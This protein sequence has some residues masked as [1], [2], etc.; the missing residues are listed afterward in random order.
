ML[1]LLLTLCVI[2][3]STYRSY[4][5][6]LGAAQQQM[7]TLARALEEHVGRTT[8]A[9]IESLQLIRENPQIKAC[10][11]NQDQACLHQELQRIATRFSQVGSFTLI[12]P[13]GDLLASSAVDHVPP[14]NLSQTHYFRIVNAQPGL[15]WYVAEQQP[16]PLGGANVIPIVAN[17]E[18]SHGVTGA[19]LVATLRPDYFYRFYKTE[20]TERLT[21]RLFRNDGI[22]LLRYPP[23]ETEIGRDISFMRFFDEVFS[24]GTAGVSTE[25]SPVDHQTLIFGWRRVDNRPLGIAVGVN[26]NDVLLAWQR[27]QVVNGVIVLLMIAAGALLLIYVL[28]QLTR[29]EKA[30]FDLYLTRAAVERGA[31]MAVWLDRNGRICYVNTIGCQRLGYTEQALRNMRLSDINPA[32]RGDAWPRFWERLSRHKHLVEESSL[33]TRTGQVFPIE[34]YSNYIVFKGEEYNCAVVRDISERRMAEQAIVRSEQ[35]LRLALEASATGLFDMP[36]D[37]RTAAVT[38][39]EYDRLLGYEPGEMVETFEKWKNQLHPDDR[40]DVLDALRSYYN[41]AAAQFAIEYRRRTR[42]GQY[43]WFQCRGRLVE[44]DESGSPTRLIGTV[45]DITE[46]KQAQ[47]RITELANFDPV[48]RLANRNLLRDELR[49]S[50]AAAERRGHLLA[51]LFL[52]LDRF[53]TVN[54]SLGHAAGDEVLKQVAQRLRGTVRRSD[55]L[56]RLGGDEFVVVLTDVKSTE[57]VTDVASHILAVFS[58]PFELEAG[59]FATSTSIGISVYPTDAES[60]DVLVRNADVAMYQAKANGRNN[61]QFFTAD[62]NARAS[63][64]LQ[65]EAS[66]RMALHNDQF[67]LHYQPQV[68][69]PDQQIVGAE[70]L[71]RWQHPEH[72][73]ISPSRFIP[74]AEDS[75]MIVTLGTWVLQSAV[76]QAGRWQAAG[77]PP[78]TIAVNL[79]PLQLHQPNLPEIVAEALADAGLDA[80]YLELE[81][82]ESVIMQEGEQVTMALHRLKKLGVRLSID[83]FGTGYS[84]L[85]Y[86]KRFA[87]DKLKVDQSFVRDLSTD[88]NDEAIV[89]AIIGLGKTLGMTVLAEGVETHE[90]LAFLERAGIDSVQG[91]L[92]SRPITAEAFEALITPGAY[93]EPGLRPDATV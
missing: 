12:A 82:T 33:R 80:Q 55:I 45:T 41:G 42:H 30:E 10:L 59:S 89:L 25:T 91:Y 90:Q 28:R 60:P 79:S 72:G 86:L 84:S 36:L 58:D 21:I 7:Q 40:E 11:G 2:G 29:L 70:A 63:E 32:I 77:L 65:L 3:W 9:A 61:F 31:D 43:H 66:M 18:S 71:I 85:S 74:I 64:R 49:L 67:K 81:V 75:R 35:Q 73:L 46:R 47:D 50:I 54:D 23:D 13:D 8:D 76:R 48:T 37:G 39:P 34:V 88:P 1:V 87:F 69:L 17:L 14:R 5:D 83:D 51:V 52:D 27:A 57:Q 24:Q 19:L 92:L 44:L 53:K 4:L 68:S 22:L 38:S 15:S 20:Q 16:D 26:R 6:R 56:A 62:L 78:I 93:V